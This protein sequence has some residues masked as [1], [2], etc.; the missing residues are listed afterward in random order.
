MRGASFGAGV[1]RSEGCAGDVGLGPGLCVFPLQTKL[2]MHDP[3]SR[4]TTHAVDSLHL[5]LGRRQR[6]E[7]DGLNVY[8]K[9]RDKGPFE[10]AAGLGQSHRLANVRRAATHPNGGLATGRLRVRRGFNLRGDPH[11]L[12][13]DGAIW[14]EPHLLLADAGEALLTKPPRLFAGDRA[15]VLPVVPGFPSS[16]SDMPHEACQPSPH[17][18][19]SG[20]GA[21]DEGLARS[22]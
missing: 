3:A 5:R 18:V 15:L 20:F 9:G 10:A 2:G 21:S 8:R 17:G 6:L 11:R 1:E 4:S 7:Q 19:L 12:D 22:T 13:L 16:A 14:F